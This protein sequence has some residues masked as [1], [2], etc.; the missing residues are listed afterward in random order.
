MFVKRDP[1]ELL[2]EAAAAEETVV[3]SEAAPIDTP[4]VDSAVTPEGK[5][6]ADTVSAEQP[7]AQAPTDVVKETP[8]ATPDPKPTVSEQKAEPKQDTSPVEK[9][10]SIKAEQA[11][12]EKTDQPTPKGES[13]AETKQESAAEVK[14]AEHKVSDSQDQAKR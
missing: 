8:D 6:V 1:A 4:A 7:Q 3:A 9:P 11:G 12:A 13:E 10:E 14:T 2:A 5:S